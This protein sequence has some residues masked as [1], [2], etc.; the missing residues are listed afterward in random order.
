M[1]DKACDAMT[2]TLSASFHSRNENF[3][4]EN[5]RKS[6]DFSFNFQRTTFI[7]FT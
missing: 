1:I 4:L 6:D 5:V 7:Y 2:C 3:A